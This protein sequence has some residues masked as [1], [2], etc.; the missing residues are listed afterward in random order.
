VTYLCDIVTYVTLKAGVVGKDSRSRKWLI[1]INNPSDHD[2]GHERIIDILDNMELEY[3]CLCDEIGENETYHTHVFIYGKNAIRFST[4]KN[5]FPPAHIDFVKGTS[6]ENK[7]YIRKEGKW[8]KDKKKETNFSETF[9]ERGDC[10]IERP[11]RRTDLEDLYD[12]INQGMTDKEIMDEEPRYM[13]CLDKIERTRQ[14]VIEAKYRDKF[15]ELYVEYHWGETGTGKTRG[16]MEKYG[17]GRVYRITDY[18]HPWDS[19]RQQDIIVFE[20]FHSNL[21]IRDMLNYLDGYPLELPC[22]YV[23]KIACYTKVIIISNMRL[24]EQYKQI[25]EEHPLVWEAFFRRIHEVKRF[26]SF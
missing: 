20:E 2:M 16:V 26:G 18:S 5:K 23:N 17:Y 22:R 10:P 25:Q 12:M 6:Q 3:W 1:T 9:K 24:T 8:L 21:K 14:T 13:M 7:D 4:V 19:Y 15:R 11:G